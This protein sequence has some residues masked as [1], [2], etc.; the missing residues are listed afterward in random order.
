MTPSIEALIGSLN[1][2][3]SREIAVRMRLTDDPRSAEIKE[4]CVHLARLVPRIKIRNDDD[5]A[6]ELPAIGIGPRIDFCGAPS[7]NDIAPFLKALTALDRKTDSIPKD[8]VRRLQNIHPA[9]EITLFIAPSCRFCPGVLDRIIPLPIET[10]GV[11]LKIIDTTLF[12]DIA[13]KNKV[14]SVPTVLVDGQYR[15]TGGVQ[16]PQ[17]CAA[18]EK[19][20]PSKLGKAILQRMITEGGAYDL[21]RMMLDSGR[22]YPAFIDLLVDENFTVRLA[23]MVTVE[24]MASM[25][26]VAARAVIEPL[27]KRY[28]QSN[29]SVKGDILYILGELRSPA[30]LS[31]LR[32]IV[33]SETNP[34]IKEAALEAIE[35]TE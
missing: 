34:E 15:W 30:I 4:F 13:E 33:D 10:E 5:A 16:L 1:S 19:R 24:E 7:G 27:W 35:K 14:R 9:A 18:V 29:D 2:V 28:H 6:G 3:L 17:L 25:D 23:A 11:R 20:D 22:L 8:I 26:I 12:G 31:D 21:A 32:S